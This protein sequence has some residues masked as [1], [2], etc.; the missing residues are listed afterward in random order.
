V[1]TSSCDGIVRLTIADTGVGIEK[2]NL[3]R[4]FDPFFSTKEGGTGLGLALTHQIIEEHG[5]T[6]TCESEVGRG[7]T[8]TISLPA[9]PGR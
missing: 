3:E 1:E 4:I 2:K 7:T 8:F 9:A 5:G 6:I